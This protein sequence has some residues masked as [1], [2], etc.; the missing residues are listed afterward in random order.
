MMD[1]LW[2]CWVQPPTRL[3]AFPVNATIACL[4]KSACPFCNRLHQALMTKDLP[5]PPSPSSLNND[6]CW[7]RRDRLTSWYARVCSALNK[8]TSTIGRKWL[9]SRPSPCCCM[10][11]TKFAMHARVSSSN[12]SLSAAQYAGSMFWSNSNALALASRSLW[13][14]CQSS[15]AFFFNFTYHIFKGLW[16]IYAKI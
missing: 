10:K 13:T 16:L 14:L 11:S 1:S 12:K 8:A 7:R 5:V 2:L 3:A 6:R 9:L 15:C 4:H